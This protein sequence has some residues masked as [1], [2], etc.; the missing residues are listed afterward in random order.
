[1]HES[2]GPVYL[3]ILGVV[4]FL[5]ALIASNRKH[6][7]R[8]GVWVLNLF[9]GWTVLG[10]IIALIWAASGE[11]RP[12]PFDPGLPKITAPLVASA[13]RAPRIAASVPCPACRQPVAAQA[14]FCAA[15]GAR[16]EWT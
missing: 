7:S 11:S 13:P 16:L 3:L 8:G 4:Y 5:P 15:C 2:A 9:L 1:M 10:W 14:N 12:K 6:P